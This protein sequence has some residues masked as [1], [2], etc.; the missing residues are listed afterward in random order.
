MRQLLEA[1]RLSPSSMNIQP[2]RFV[3]YDSKIH[4]YTKKHAAEDMSR[5]RLDELNFGIM[6][7]NMMTAAEEWI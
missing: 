2:W 7:A 3:V 4:I 6:F 1:A 5:Y